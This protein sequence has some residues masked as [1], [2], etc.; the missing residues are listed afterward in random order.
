MKKSLSVV[1][2]MLAVLM[3]ISALPMTAFAV[4][5]DLADTGAT[6]GSVSIVIDE[7]I[8]G[9]SPSYS[10]TESFGAKWTLKNMGLSQTYKN[11]ICWSE[12]GGD[13][14]KHSSAVFEGG[15]EYTVTLVV[16][17]KDSADKFGRDTV[18]YFNGDETTEFTK[19]FTGSQL[20]V[21]HTFYCEEVV[22]EYGVSFGSLEVTSAN[23]DDILGDGGKAKFDPKT[24]TLTL[25][26]PVLPAYA[27]DG[28]NTQ[29]NC[30]IR[31]TI[32]GSYHMPA[33]SAY[34]YGIRGKMLTLDGDFTFRG[35]EY[36]G[37]VSQGGLTIK[38][39][40]IKAV[41]VVAGIRTTFGDIVIEDGV[42][43]VD[44]EGNTS[45]IRAE[46]GGII[47]LGDNLHFEYPADAELNSYKSKVIDSTGAEVKR[48]MIYPGAPTV[49][50]KKYSLWLGNTRVTSTNK[51]DILGDGG[52]AK[53]D[54]ETGTLTL[55]DPAIVGSY[56]DTGDS[57]TTWTYKICSSD[58]LTV[59][60]SYHL[61][62]TEADYGIRV[63]AGDLTLDGDF[64]FSGKFAVSTNKN[65]YINGGTLKAIGTNSGISSGDGIVISDNI[66]RV[67]AGGDNKAIYAYNGKLIIGEDLKI[68][69]PE[70]ATVLVDYGI[71]KDKN[72]EEAKHVVIVPGTSEPLPN[73][74]LYDLWLGDRQV[75]SYNK[76]D[77]LD[78]GGKAKFDPET[79]T[80][81]FNKPNI[82]SYSSNLGVIYAEDMD[83]TVLGSL[84]MTITVNR[85]CILVKN[86]DLILDGDFRIVNNCDKE[87]AIASEKDIT[88][89]GGSL[90]AESL[91]NY[92]VF[93]SSGE[94]TVGAD[95]TRFEAI[96][97]AHDNSYVYA[98]V[99]DSYDISDS[100]EITTPEGCKQIGRIHTDSNDNPAWHIVIK[101]KTEHPTEP[102]TP[103]EPDEPAVD[104]LLGDV[105]NSGKVNVFD[106]SYI[107]K[108]T[109]GTKGYPDYKNMDK[110]SIDFLCADV[111]GTGTINI[112]DAAI[113]LKHATGDKSVA[114]YGI[115]EIIK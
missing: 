97:I 69:E 16:V 32:K 49:S 86:G 13:D 41:G 75:N 37:I 79:N 12:V 74:V 26:D 92:A 61:S 44:A 93:T 70:Y 39:G 17:P 71:I 28:Y 94:L 63:N 72:N 38:G 29:I 98:M 54:P 83:L 9:Q 7:P 42:T 11:G 105:D 88:V 27:G 24:S 90:Y 46:S 103:T 50:E 31:L 76:D 78:D 89:R 15:K 56:S 108:G 115:G 67:E 81:T 73:L 114:K 82:T 35:K 84:D 19:N 110:S 64:T 113:V 55:N 62:Y 53:Y 59:K 112:F 107:L 80:L 40:T 3:L 91:S 101:P 68:E 33:N 22:V 60:G 43:K 10:I 65:V 47:S 34:P 36:S 18:V 48:V 2:L 30:N 111:D 20:T 51:D 4:T 95:V 1:S 66:R 6:I 21:T 8:A 57:G 14:L 99:A 96:N 52:K 100:L 45:A 25:N 58:D 87:I 106:A 77:I 102:N 109:T 23:K 104:R 85:H 5:A